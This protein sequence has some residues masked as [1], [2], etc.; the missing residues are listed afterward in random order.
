MPISPIILGNISKE[1]CN[2]VYAYIDTLKS[3]DKINKSKKNLETYMKL[4][5]KYEAEHN[6]LIKNFDN[7]AS[8]LELPNSYKSAFLNG[9]RK[10]QIEVHDIVNDFF[11]VEKDSC[12]KYNDLLNFM[13]SIQGTYTVQGNQILFKTNY[14]LNK[15]NEYINDIQQ[16]SQKEADIQNSIKENQKLK[17][18]KL[19]NQINLNNK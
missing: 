12:S 1:K 19:I 7:E 15:Y 2:I 17:R 13:L 3:T 18:D 11:K 8:T 5:D 6:D 4:L 16:L 9:F 10:S 14:T